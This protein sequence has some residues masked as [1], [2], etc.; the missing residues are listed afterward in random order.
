MHTA[1]CTSEL[2]GKNWSVDPER[3]IFWQHP[4]VLLLTAPTR[5]HR[6]WV[7]N[8]KHLQ[9]MLQF[10][11]SLIKEQSQVDCDSLLQKIDM[12][13]THHVEIM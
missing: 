5:Y 3:I 12:Q 9:S 13:T 4:P 8:I 7:L 10:L 1:I 6:K 11:P 2:K